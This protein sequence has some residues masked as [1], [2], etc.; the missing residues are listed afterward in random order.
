MKKLVSTKLKSGVLDFLDQLDEEVIITKK[1]TPFAKIIPLKNSSAHL[2]G[3]LKG[4]LK[5]KG[6]ILN[7]G[8]KWNAES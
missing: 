6:N 1:G 4:K 7:T 8:I 5:I 2:I 3:K